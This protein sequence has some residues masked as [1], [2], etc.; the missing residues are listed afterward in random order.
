MRRGALPTLAPPLHGIQG[1]AS[2]RCRASL[3]HSQGPPTPPPINMSTISNIVDRLRHPWGGRE[4]QSPA[5]P[6]AASPR[7]KQD[8]WRSVFDV[9]FRFYG[10]CGG[11]ARECSAHN[12]R[13]QRGPRGLCRR[14][15]ACKASVQLSRVVRQRHQAARDTAAAA[16]VRP[17]TR[18]H[19]FATPPQ[20]N[21]NPRQVRQR[22]RC[23]A[24]C[25]AQSRAWVGKRPACQRRGR[26]EGRGRARRACGRGGKRRAGAR[27]RNLQVQVGMVHA[28]Q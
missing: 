6:D 15:S 7:S 22:G 20:P 27:P 24:V 25:G 17:L 11:A 18:R 10:V 19:S 3:K 5:S 9:R 28:L 21:S 2:R 1:G 26:A 23:G 13:A 4:P 8:P 12:P 16:A 14:A